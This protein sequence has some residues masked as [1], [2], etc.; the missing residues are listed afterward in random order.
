MIDLNTI[1][2]GALQEKF[3]VEFTKVL[4][5]LKDPNTKPNFKRKL[6]VELTFQTN[7]ER[8]LS[9]VTVDTKTKLAERVGVITTFIVDRDGKGNIIASELKKQIKGQTH[10]LIDEETGEIVAEDKNLIKFADARGN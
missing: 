8:E 3:N 2:D 1:A 7:E 4:E 10:M 6:I 9:I 5:N